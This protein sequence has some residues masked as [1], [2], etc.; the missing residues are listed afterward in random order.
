MGSVLVIAF[1]DPYLNKSYYAYNDVHIT[2]TSFYLSPF[3]NG[4]SCCNVNAIKIK[5]VLLNNISHT[6]TIHPPEAG[7]ITF[8]DYYPWGFLYR[9]SCDLLTS[10]FYS[11]KVYDSTFKRNSGTGLCINAPQSSEVYVARSAILDH[12]QGGVVI[13][14]GHVGTKVM[15]YGNNISHNVNTLV[16]SASASALSI[17]ATE[18]RIPNNNRAQDVPRLFRNY[19]QFVGNQRF[20]NT[21]IATVFISTNVRARITDSEF[22]DKSSSL[23]LYCLGIILHTEEVPYTF[24]RPD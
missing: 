5:N 21:L 20:G 1:P 3:G 4:L 12:Q 7:L 16:G 19:C 14:S 2:N 8:C 24:I 11:L 18:D 22:M 13:T 10:R 17:Y 15:F 23:A 6:S 9:E